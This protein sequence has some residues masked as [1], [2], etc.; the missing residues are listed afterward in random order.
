MVSQDLCMCQISVTFSIQI[1][2]VMNRLH[3]TRNQ[4]LL[5]CKVAGATYPLTCI[6]QLDP[7]P[8]ISDTS[9]VAGPTPYL[10]SNTYTVSGAT[11]CPLLSNTYTV[12]GPNPC[13][14]LSDTSTEARST[15]YCLLS[16]TPRQLGPP[17]VLSYSTSEPYR[18][19]KMLTPPS[20]FQATSPLLSLGATVLYR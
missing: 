6:R 16:N 17:H 10:L 9:T 20:S 8:L 19:F 15:P 1:H 18:C 13:P 2:P 11:P 7:C 3:S 12:A 14:F 5:F 4:S